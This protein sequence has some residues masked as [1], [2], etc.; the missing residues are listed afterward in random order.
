MA[1]SDKIRRLLHKTNV[2]ERLNRIITHR[3]KVVMVFPYRR[4][5]KR[6]VS[7]LL[8]EPSQ[9]WETKGV[10]VESDDGLEVIAGVCRNG[11]FLSQIIRR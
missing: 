9:N 7:V 1:Y 5:N 10:Y 2:M 3:N 6:L 11:V 4:V 8:M